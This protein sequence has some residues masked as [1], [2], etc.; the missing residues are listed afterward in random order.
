MKRRDEEEDCDKWK[1]QSISGQIE[2]QLYKYLD[3]LLV[4]FPPLKIVDLLCL[5][6]RFA[7]KCAI[8]SLTDVN[9]M[10]IIA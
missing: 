6:C 7:G 3:N 1:A 2:R 4:L 10:V 9:L 5:K 8:A